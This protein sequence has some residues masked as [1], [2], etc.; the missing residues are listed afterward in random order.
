MQILHL[1]RIGRQCCGKHS[2][3]DHSI[4]NKVIRWLKTRIL[5]MRHNFIWTDKFTARVIAR[6]CT[7]SSDPDRKTCSA[8][9]FSLLDSEMPE[10]ARKLMKFIISDKEN[11]FGHV[12]LA[13]RPTWNGLQVMSS[14]L[15]AGGWACYARR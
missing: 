7:L 8:N 5:S 2:H 1:R 14:F 10:T 13:K 9:L 15:M 11:I 3:K 4:V 6:K 12:T